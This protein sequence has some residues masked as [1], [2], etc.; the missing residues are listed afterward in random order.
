MARA[1]L[2]RSP[3]GGTQPRSGAPVAGT[4]Q[5]EYPPRLPALGPD[6]SA[7]SRQRPLGF[8]PGLF[9]AQPCERN[10]GQGRRTRPCGAWP[11]AAPRRRM[12][13]LP[14]PITS[15]PI[16]RMIYDDAWKSRRN[17]D[18]EIEGDVESNTKIDP[19][20][21]LQ[22]FPG[23]APGRPPAPALLAVLPSGRRHSR[24]SPIPRPPLRSVAC[25]S[26]NGATSRRW[27]ASTIEDPAPWFRSRSAES[28]AKRQ[29]RR[30]GLFPA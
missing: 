22:D 12:H 5:S 2:S 30:S 8:C 29:P 24:E 16:Q 9:P 17:S 1:R 21:Y 19:R 18:L 14:A 13:A 23:V 27:V 20:S 28:V 26:C 15:A 3:S 11:S 4:S 7:A 25:E 10:R 6:A